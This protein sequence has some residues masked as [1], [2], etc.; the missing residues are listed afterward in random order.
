[1]SYEGYELNTWQRIKLS[2]LGNVKVDR[3]EKEHGY[4]DLYLFKC[5]KHKLALNYPQ[6][7]YEILHCKKCFEEVT[8]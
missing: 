6:G 7:H 1:M 3:L 5:P 4:V 2:L 8:R